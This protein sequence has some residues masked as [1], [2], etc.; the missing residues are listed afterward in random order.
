MDTMIEA[1]V[2]SKKKRK[3]ILV[4]AATLVAIA[5]VSWSMR[6]VFV[7]SIDKKRFR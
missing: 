1:E 3:T 5:L 4:I 7:P 2:Q 6:I